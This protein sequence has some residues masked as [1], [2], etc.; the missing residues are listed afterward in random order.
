MCGIG[1]VRGQLERGLEMA[2]RGS[3][4]I[5]SP[6]DTRNRTGCRMFQ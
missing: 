2:L 5:V 4:I 6:I 1:K 3:R